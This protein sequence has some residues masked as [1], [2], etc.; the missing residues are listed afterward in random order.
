MYGEYVNGNIY[1]FALKSKHVV[2]V[3]VVSNEIRMATE[4]Q[5]N[6]NNKHENKTD[7]LIQ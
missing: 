2:V 4:K 3:V 5:A 7:A 1:C 6:N